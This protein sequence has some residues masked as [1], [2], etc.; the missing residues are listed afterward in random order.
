VLVLGIPYGRGEPTT[1]S[2]AIAR[3]A[4]GRDYHYAHRDRMRQLRGRLRALAP[5][6]RSYACVDSGA[7]MEKA[8]AERAGLGFL[9]KHGLLIHRDYGSWLTLSLMVLDR[10]VDRYASPLPRQ[11]GDCRACLDACPT[12]AFPAP[13]VL[14]ARR[15][16]SYH[17]VEN[18]GEVPKDVAAALG[19]RAFGCDV[20]Q[21]V[22]P[23]NQGEHPPGDPR[24]ASRPLGHLGA[25]ELAALDPT[26]YEALAA[27]TPVRRIGYHGLRR[28]ACLALGSLR[29]HESRE[30][31]LRL[32]ADP[33]PRVAAAARWAL[34]RL[35][36]QP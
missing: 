30:L 29:D 33:E 15:C 17:T 1:G 25:A 21:E 31:L 23:W 8:W 27:G 35:A 5:A 11:C 2:A 18:H 22:C 24:Q 14:D 3:Y 10:A 32:S 36:T 4:R 16:L 28:N 9:G 7:A 26:Q 6:L 13:F 19:P 20:C 34:E 12:A